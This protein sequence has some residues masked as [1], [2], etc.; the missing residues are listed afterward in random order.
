MAL[1]VQLIY[2]LQRKFDILIFKINTYMHVRI[3]IELF[4]KV[5]MY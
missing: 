2:F 5:Q 4:I 1:K 3:S